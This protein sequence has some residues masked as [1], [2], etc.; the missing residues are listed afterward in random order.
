MYALDLT[1]KPV[2]VKIG[3]KAWGQC[4]NPLFHLA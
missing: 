3:R 2:D 1:E 4:Y